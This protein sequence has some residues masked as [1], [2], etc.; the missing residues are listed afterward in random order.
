MT[1]DEYTNEALKT[2][3]PDLD[4]QENVLHSLLMLSSEIGEISS[5]YQKFFFQGHDIPDPEETAKE[6]GDVLWALNN[7]CDLLGYSLEEVA[8]M[9]IAKLR[10]RYGDKFTAQGSINRIDT[11]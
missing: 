5:T 2:R 10:K 9:N 7:L 8:E 6:C 11:N 4:W 3:N 1:F